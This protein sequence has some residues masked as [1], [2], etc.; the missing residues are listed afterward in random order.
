MTSN[1]RSQGGGQ[2]RLGEFVLL[3]EVGRG[4][5]GVVY[6]ARQETLGRIVAVKTLPS[7]AG[8]DKD[9]VA[10]FKRE[11]ESAARISHRGIVP[12]YAVGE[13]QGTYYYAME[14]VDGPSLESMLA[15]LAGRNPSRLLGSLAEETSLAQRCPGFLQA[16][17]DCTP[18]GQRYPASCAAIIADLANALVVAHNAHVIHRDLK[19]SNVLLRRDGRPML[20]DFGLSRDQTAV[21]LTQSGD[22]VGTPSY[23][24][25]EQAFGQKDLDARVDIYGLGA[26]LYEMLALRPPFDGA[27]AVEIMR[28]IVEDEPPP[29]RALNTRVPANLATIV[30]KC[31][32]KNRDH[33]Y[34]VME[35]VE[36]DLRAWLAGRPIAASAPSLWSRALGATVRHRRGIGVAAATTAVLSLA[37]VAVGFWSNTRAQQEGQSLLAAARGALLERADLDTAL[38]NYARAD[39]LLRDPAAISA[40]RAEHVAAAVQHH[41]SAADKLE[42]LGRVLDAVP[43]SSRDAG[44]HDMRRRVRGQAQC[45]LT[46]HLLDAETSISLSRLVGDRFEPVAPGWPADGV[47]EIG[48]YLVQV[49]R[50]NL[51]PA[52]V[53][54]SVARDTKTNI[55][56][57]Q[58]NLDA[59][60]DDEVMIATAHEPG[61]PFALARSELSGATWKR[62][63]AQLTADQVAEFQGV[64]D[65]GGD[66]PLRNL[67]FRQAR[68]LAALARGHLPTVAELTLAARGHAPAAAMA[69]PW[70]SVFAPERVNADPMKASHTDPV[71]S[72]RDGASP[73]G[74]LHL[75]GNVAEITAVGS[76]GVARAHGGDHLSAPEQVR[77]GATVPLPGFDT[78]LTGTGVRVA[79]FLYPSR[80]EDAAAAT[81]AG[82][83]FEKL[84][85]E[86]DAVLLTD[87]E[88]DE[89]GGT[90]TRLRLASHLLSQRPSLELP[91]STPGFL[92]EGKPTVR[93]G[94]VEVDVSTRV[95][96]DGESSDVDV[97]LG[98]LARGQ[99]FRIEATT[100]LTPLSGLRG[101]ADGYVLQIPLKAT[102]RIPASYRVRLPELSR[103]DEVD[104]PPTR[105]FQHGKRPVLVWE[106]GADAQ[107]ERTFSGVVRF[108]KDGF[109]T[110][111]WPTKAAALAVTSELFTAMADGN[112]ASLRAL[113]APT[114]LLLPSNLGVKPLTDPARTTRDL[115]TNVRF[116]DAT[117]V[118]GVVTTDLVVD[119]RVADGAEMRATSNW[120]LRVHWR[121]VGDR[122]QVLQVAPASASDTGRI[123][124]GVY[125]HDQLLVRLDPNAGG[126]SPHKVSLSRTVSHLAAMQVELRAPGDSKGQW[127]TLLGTFV[128]G[129]VDAA[130]MWQRLS[131]GV[132]LAGSDGRLVASGEQKL[133][134]HTAVREDWQF[135]GGML[136]ERWLKVRA[137]RRWILLR[138]Q[139]VGENAQAA[140]SRWR[141]A[142]GWFD[143]VLAR[144]HIE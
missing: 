20:V 19:P 98:Q 32:A 65:D 12:I 96:G 7:F 67:S 64:V 46:G 111:S 135:G 74:V 52:V 87:W 77:I 39:Q 103:V 104:P 114:F 35:A 108:R 97:P 102:G 119:W 29:L 11:A 129:E 18:T 100:D 126:P 54:F 137:G 78:S 16:R 38:V 136:R 76:D 69:Y 105:A 14:L 90:R 92:H 23:M 112:T 1:T 8:L 117:A 130:A 37:G 133:G 55:A 144:L 132:Q 83:H 86:G 139:A 80:E 85:R 93:V 138:L 122:V 61:R 120:P 21:G 107:G 43:V 27:T 4:G 110:T 6:R 25:P 84:W 2:R 22:A 15:E 17:F 116:V 124:K 9:A 33:R 63:C 49:E 58:L 48:H 121:R 47:L 118:G 143:S 71:D 72:R 42:W 56:V 99:L 26:T 91:W 70:G 81:E 75:A 115:F 68:T 79:R 66:R 53:A 125:V 36:H 3:E 40:A 113:L 140:A 13:E 141:A 131:D 123:D 134:K 24:A 109:L 62:L 31:L 142:E 60:A 45:T 127:A 89:V 82:S 73:F 10:R 34:P 57:P 59:L 128:D 101:L 44:W 5:M 30:H 28:Q 41:Y 95:S 50:I 94:N 88:V 51:A 106:F